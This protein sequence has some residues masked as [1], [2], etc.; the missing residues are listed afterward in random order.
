[1]SVRAAISALA[2]SER[3]SDLLRRCVDY[4]GD[5]DT[6]ATIALAAG[7]Y[8]AEVEQDLPTHLLYGL[9]DTAFGWTYIEDLDARPLS[10]VRRW[11]SLSLISQVPQRP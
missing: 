5:V 9:E 1:M 4:T 10:P 8:S 6:V 3:L 7:S 2:A 11:E